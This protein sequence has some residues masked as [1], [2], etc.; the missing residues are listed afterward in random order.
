MV[1]GDYEATQAGRS[2]VPARNSDGAVPFFFLIACALGGV[3]PS[4]LGKN[5]RQARPG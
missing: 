2:P 4:S 1:A 5:A 3:S